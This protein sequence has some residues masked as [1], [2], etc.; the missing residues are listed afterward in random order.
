MPRY[1]SKAS[2]AEKKGKLTLLTLRGY[3]R[4]MYH[5]ASI[6]KSPTPLAQPVDWSPVYNHRLATDTT[7]IPSSSSSR[8][9]I[10]P[11]D[12]AL[13]QV[14]LLSEVSDIIREGLQLGA[15][16]REEAQHLEQIWERVHAARAWIEERLNREARL[17]PC[18]PCLPYPI[19]HHWFRGN[20]PPPALRDHISPLRPRQSLRIHTCT[21]PQKLL[22]PLVI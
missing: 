13:R 14:F 16:Q 11:I 1:V 21:F 3:T 9:H 6:I 18:D 20:P 22:S 2:H 8:T 17:P 12:Y 10:N 7:I 15:Q 19:L 5:P 4:S